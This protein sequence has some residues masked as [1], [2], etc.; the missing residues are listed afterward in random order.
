MTPRFMTRCVAATALLA[1]ACT[2]T[3]ID[4]PPTAKSFDA[5]A[6]QAQ[7]QAVDGLLGVPA[8]RSF[9][10]MSVHFGL[11]AATTAAVTGARELGVGA[12]SLSS[13][14][15]RREAVASAARVLAATSAQDG[16]GVPALP[17]QARGTTFIWDAAQHRYV[18]ASGRSGAPADG[19]RFILYAVNPLTNEPVVAAEIGYADLTDIGT[20]RATGVGLRLQL[21]SGATTYLDYSVT[22][23]GTETTGSLAV[24]GFITDGT[25]RLNFQIAAGGTNVPGASTGQV[26]FQFDIPDRAFSA[27]GDVRGSESLGGQHVD[28]V[29][30][31]HDA[32][33]SFTVDSDA[34][35]VNAV[36][37]VND[38][39]F[40]TVTGDPHQPVVRGAGGRELRP[41]EA[42]ALGHMMGLADTAFRMLG[43]LLKPVETIL[44]PH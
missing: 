16:A 31:V 2:G 12:Q 34:R 32:R 39:V 25:T 27:T 14:D 18:A 15:V 44:G 23:D 37:S 1:S 3:E 43:E 33:I 20:G 30:R 10:A 36:I 11:G 26:T 5:P 4:A 38:Q 19:V 17:P 41:D 9:T 40:A 13:V 28:L 8:W 42:Q 35:S 6:A 21:V 24:S 22:A 7:L 29:V